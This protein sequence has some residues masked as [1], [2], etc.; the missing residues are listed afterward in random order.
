M[1]GRTEW[2]HLSDGTV[3]PHIVVPMPEDG[4]CLFHA[5][6]Y[7]MTDLTDTVTAYQIRSSIVSYVVSNWDHLEVYTCDENGA[8][9]PNAEV[10]SCA[11]L[12]VN[13]YGSVSELM[14]AGAIFPFIFEV[15]ECNTLRRS[16]GDS[17]DIKRMRFRG[18]FLNGHFDVLL[19]LD[20][21]H[22]VDDSE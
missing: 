14:A 19:R 21:L 22:F 8:T 9:Y 5:L 15:Y 18:S 2:L 7:L 4:S 13:T 1:E 3:M 12:N 17:G 16:F 6:T 11:M 10:Y 20:G